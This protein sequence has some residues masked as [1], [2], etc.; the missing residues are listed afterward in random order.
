MES[1]KRE[2]SNPFDRMPSDSPS[3][4]P[5]DRP[6]LWNH[7]GSIEA[8][9][10]K[11]EFMATL[12]IKNIPDEL[13]EKLKKSAEANRRSINS[14][15][16]VCIERTVASHRVNPDAV[17]AEAQTLRSLTVGHPVENDEFNQAKAAGRP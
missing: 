6:S 7:N 13:Y 4:S 1:G 3:D 16:I 8:P 9:L 17:I 2:I 12:T 14:E 15:I 10:S 5:V 11:E